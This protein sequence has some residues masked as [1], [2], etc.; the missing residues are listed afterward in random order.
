[1]HWRTKWKKDFLCTF[2][3][4]FPLSFI[5]KNENNHWH[6]I[7]K[8]FERFWI[9]SQFPISVNFNENNEAISILFTRFIK[10]NVTKNIEVT[11]ECLSNTLSLCWW[12][13]S[14]HNYVNSSIKIVYISNVSFKNYSLLSYNWN[15]INIT[16]L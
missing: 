13:P 10:G 9:L 11:I 4:L 14:L 1:M 5:M 15:K 16:K 7:P 12:T 2:V 8:I 6:I 3:T